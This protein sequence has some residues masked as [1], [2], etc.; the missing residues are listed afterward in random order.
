MVKFF[1]KQEDI[2]FGLTTALKATA[3]KSTLPILTGIKFETLDQKI[4]LTSTDL[5]L[6]I[7]C[8]IPAQI[9]SKGIFVISAKTLTDLI[10]KLP[11]KDVSFQQISDNVIKVECEKISMEFNTFN[12][13]E[14]PELDPIS[15][16]Y[17]FTISQGLFR[18]CIRQTIFAIARQEE[19]RPILTGGYME[20]VGDSFTLVALDGFRLS[21][22]KG[23]L[24]T[25]LDSDLK[26][27]IPRK[28]LDELLKILSAAD[29]DEIK[30][31]LSKNKIFFE[32]DDI[33]MSSRL[34]DGQYMNY[35]G[36]IPKEFKMSIPLNRQDILESVER[37]S[38]IAAESKNKILK[39]SIAEDSI[40]IEAS[41]DLGKTLEKLSI[42][43]GQIQEGFN[44]AFN[45][46]YL[47]DALRAIDTEDVILN[48]NGPNQPCI[49]T[50][51]DGK[52]SQHMVL[53]IKTA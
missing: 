23:R 9:I 47:L 51:S 32:I 4:K 8:Y 37:A 1:C 52:N 33:R 3:T 34:I 24:S 27:I 49:I 15:G 17:S 2:L 50:P 25:I 29:K 7:E 40:L 6:G 26:A 20:A 44:I 45:Y 19:S 16:K 48:I 53:P 5:E 30:I 10:R 46:G 14:F 18:N 42:K 13:M 21:L 11:D 22:S 39:M 28:A 41:S 36:F 12:F 38:L 43:G 31:T 35:N